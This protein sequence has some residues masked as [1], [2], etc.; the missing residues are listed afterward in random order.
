MSPDEFYKEYIERW[1]KED[2]QIMQKHEGLNFPLA[3]CAASYIDFLGGF[4][5]GMDRREYKNAFA[6]LRQCFANPK[7]YGS[8]KFFADL[9]RNPLTHEYFPRGGIAKHGQAEP[10]YRDSAGKLVLDVTLFAN[11]F[12]ESLPRF[13]QLI[14]STHLLN[15][16][17]RI[18]G[19]E[20]MKEAK[21]KEYIVELLKM[22]QYDLSGSTSSSYAKPAVSGLRPEIAYIV[23]TD[24]KKD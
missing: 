5:S 11:D 14:N 9:I 19:M 23:Q 2:I 8:R 6:Y 21:E 15:F 24:N 20:E 22:R 18:K 13:L 4:L 12:L 7:R 17:K 16:Q 1:M 10:L 3:L